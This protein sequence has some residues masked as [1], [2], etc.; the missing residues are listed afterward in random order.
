MLEKS[1]EKRTPPFSK[2][3]DRSNDANGILLKTNV[4]HAANS[5]TFSGPLLPKNDDD[6]MRRYMRRNKDE[7]MAH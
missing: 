4:S 2:S 3:Y 5:H 7:A 6:A 1:E